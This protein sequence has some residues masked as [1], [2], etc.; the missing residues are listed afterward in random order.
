MS[1][2]KKFYQKTLTE[3][4]AI[5]SKSLSEETAQTLQQQETLD[6][7][8]AN[9]IIENF[10][11][12]YGVP[13]GIAPNFLI[14]GRLFHAPMAT[15]EPSVIAAASFG[16][17]TIAKSG[18][19]T[20]EQSERA[21]I[22]EIAL[23][24]VEHIQKVQQDI[25]KQKSTLLDIANAAYPSIVKRGGGA[26]KLDVCVKKSA[27]DVLFLIVYLTVDTQEAMGANM[28]NTMLEALKPYLESIAHAPALLS[29]LSNYATESIVSVSCTISPHFL[30]RS[31]AIAGEEVI[32]RIILAQELASADIYRATTHNKGIMN[33]ISAITLATGNDTRAI[34]AGA[35]AF[36]AR[37]GNYQPLTTW[38]REQNGYLKGTLTLPLPI[39]FVGGSIAIH[40]S[41]K[42]AKELSLTKNAKELSALIAC[43]G[44]AQNLSALRALVTDGIQKGHMALQLKSLA[45][46]IGANESEIPSLIAHL[47]NEKI[48]NQDIARHY[49]QT[50]RK[51]R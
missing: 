43:V 46:S 30:T 48:I 50:L 10:V 51:E 37:T 15:E 23:Y 9:T 6:Y 19:F 14:D 49:L 18:G 25:L 5:L 27:N 4:T 3:R 29:I 20:I 40:P 39:G 35:H 45:L 16:A 32:D 28:L 44:L 22:G 11:H 21:M 38:T 7:S 47:K 42:L 12:V 1:D 17:Q 13:M 26:R 34:E 24:N 8:T 31:N 33:G 41:A 36:A 2:F